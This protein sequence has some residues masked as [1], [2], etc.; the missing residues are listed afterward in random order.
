MPMIRSNSDVLPW[1]TCPRN[2]MTGGRGSSSGGIV[3][4]VF[5]FGQELLFEF[6]VAAE[7]DLDAE[8]RGQTA[9]PFPGRVRR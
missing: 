4:F 6:D 8:F 2:V 1:S 5:Q 3:F 9:R 7:I